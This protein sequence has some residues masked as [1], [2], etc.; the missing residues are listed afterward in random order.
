[1]SNCYGF[2]PNLSLKV[3]FLFQSFLVIT[4]LLLLL[5]FRIGGNEHPIK[6]YARDAGTDL[7][8]YDVS[9]RKDFHHEFK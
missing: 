1:M 9:A 7:I 8:G 2:S 5:L 6:T 4:V 3:V